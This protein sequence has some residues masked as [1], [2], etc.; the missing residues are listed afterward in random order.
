MSLETLGFLSNE[1]ITNVMR[2]YA[3]H[4]VNKI[5]FYKKSPSLKICFYLFICY[6]QR[7]FLS[8]NELHY[9]D[10]YVFVPGRRH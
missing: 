9:G 2:N 10:T 3:A 8:R 7:V 4:N 1:S 5:M 6:F